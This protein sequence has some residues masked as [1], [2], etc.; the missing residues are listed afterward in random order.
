MTVCW[1]RPRRTC[2]LIIRERL[3][4]PEGR[5]V[6][7]AGSTRGGEEAVLLAV[8]NRLKISF[9]DLILILVPRHINRCPEIENLF[10]TQGISYQLYSRIISTEER[11]R[12]AV[13]LVDRIG[14]L[15]ALYSVATLVFC[16]A[17]LVPKGGQNIFE[18]AAWGK[19]VFYGPHM[20]DFKDA[21][22][23]L[24]EVG[25]GIMVRDQEELE[26]QMAYY[27]E[28]PEERVSRGEAGREILKSQTGLTKKAA[29]IIVEEIRN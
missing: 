2:R 13:I 11:P 12:E 24:E 23:P 19:L 9:P 6:I 16:G 28:H 8:Y 3:Q 5:P 7:V 17:S 27:L 29:E 21:R 18:P 14:D 4:L 22:R 10:Q 1:I 25:A 20:D 26:R 15:F